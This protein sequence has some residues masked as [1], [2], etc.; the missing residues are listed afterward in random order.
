MVLLTRSPYLALLVLLVLLFLLILP[1]PVLEHMSAWRHVTLRLI[2]LPLLVPLSW[3]DMPQHATH[4]M[5]AHMAWH[6]TNAILA[7]V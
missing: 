4:D 5:D 1:Q 2:P 3:H 7:Q 6:Y